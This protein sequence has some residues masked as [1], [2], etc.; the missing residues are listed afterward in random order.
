[1]DAMNLAL[2]EFDALR[3][4]YRYL[5]MHPEISRHEVNTH[6]YIR[7]CLE[8][9]GIEYLAPEDNITIAVI[10]GEHEGKTCAIRSDT[11]AL[12]VSEQTGLD[13]ASC[14]P[15][16]M[17]ACGHDGHTAIGISCAKILN[18][19]KKLLHGRV[20]VIFQPA[21]EGE[22]GAQA[23]MDTGLV[24]D[25]DAFF[26]VHLWSTFDSGE[27]RVRTGGASASTD[28]FTVR[29]TGLS[30]HGAMPEVCIDP[31]PC[32][33]ALVGQLQ[34]IV[35]RFSSPFQPVVVTI[36]SFHAGTRCNII[37]EDAVLEGTIRTCD[38]D[39][40]RAV[41]EKFDL[42]VK[43][44]CESFGCR[45][46]IDMRPACGV[47][48]NDEKLCALARRTAKEIGR[49][50]LE[51]IPTMIGDDFGDYRSIAPVCYM[52]VGVRNPDIDAVYAHHHPKFRID[53]NA[54]PLSTAWLVKSCEMYLKNR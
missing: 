3:S 28:M 16:V 20:K 54:L 5:H 41:H 49:E 25:V 52:R 1:M 7:Q 51:D 48:F 19:Q 30:G 2:A 37:A 4:N 23:V 39:V 8:K 14:N 27:L 24:S 22:L 26:G 50:P 35:S 33:S 43:N 15:G 18:D 44:T 38:P 32:A 47:T 6:A 31:I 36:G 9:N 46:E 53:E 17:H 29:I 42:M 11:D 12:Q 45:W 21:E 13:Y 34:T 40:Y 10:E